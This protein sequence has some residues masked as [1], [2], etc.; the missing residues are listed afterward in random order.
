[1]PVGQWNLQWLNHNAQRRYPIAQDTTVTDTTGVFIIPDDFIVELD[2][3]VSAGMN[4][5]PGQFFILNIGAFASGFS[6]VVGYQPAAGGQPIPVASALI[7][8]QTHQ[9][10]TLYA[11]GGIAPFDDTIGKIMIG[12]LTN[13]LKQPPGFWTFTLLTTR[14]EP[15]AIRPILRGVTSI[16]CVNGDQ[17]SL[18]LFGDIQFVAGSNM[19][20]VPVIDGGQTSIRFSA[21]DGAGTIDQC[22]CDGAAQ[23]GPILRIDGIGPTAGGDFFIVGTTCLQIEPITNGIRL[24]DTC[25]QPCCGCPE[26][27]RVTQDLQLLRQQAAGVQEFV[28]LLQNSVTAMDM[29]VLGS[30]LGDRGCSTCL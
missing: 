27:E 9:R 2:L 29:V 19:Q 15:D 30:R 17:V 3:P 7:P 13:I 8:I 26:L 12:D 23:G 22:V 1:L 20:I 4:V 14:L 16:T 5:D 24:V 6:V 10:N 21:I 28:S 11:L 25:A 18:P